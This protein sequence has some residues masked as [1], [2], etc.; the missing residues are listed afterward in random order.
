MKRISVLTLALLVTALGTF[1]T[2][3][4]G[5]VKTEQKLENFQLSQKS[6]PDNTG[7]NQRDSKLGRP[8]SQNQSNQKKDVD[9]TRELRRAIMETKGLSIDAQNVKIITQKGKVTL[10]GPVESENEKN[11]IDDLVKNCGSVASYVNQLEVKKNN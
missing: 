8:T 11:L 7:K 1:V 10:R 4:A 9:I 3:E 6:A 2:V 5:E